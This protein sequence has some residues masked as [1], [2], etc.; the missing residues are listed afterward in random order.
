MYSDAELAAMHDVKEVF[1]PANRL[2]PGKVL[3]AQISP[4]DRIPAKMPATSP[5]QPASPEEAAAGLRACTKAERSVAIGHVQVDR[6][7]VLRLSTTALRDIRLFAPDDLFITVDAGLSLNAVQTFLAEHGLQTPVASPWPAATVGGL[8]A[9]NCNGPL[10]LRY[11]S[12]RDVMLCA[13][14]VLADGR[15][16]RAG[17][18]LVKNVAGYDLPKVFVGSWGTLGLLTD[19]TLK[20]T[21]RPRLRRTL[22]VPVADLTAGLKLADVI[23]PHALVASG[24]VLAPAAMVAGLAEEGYALL[25]TAEGVA[26]DV[27]EELAAVHQALYGAGAPLI[28]ETSLDATGAWQAFL[29]RASQASA[30]AVR[31]GVP[32]TAMPAVFAEAPAAIEQS[33]LLIDCGCGL[34][35][36]VQ[37]KSSETAPAAWLTELRQAA[38]R[39]GGYAIVQADDA[40]DTG[41]L[42]NRWGER[43]TSLPLMQRLKQR[44]DPAGILNPGVFL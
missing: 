17:R 3:P 43:S 5:W 20:L 25:Y 27:D 42:P 9:Q 15:I 16:I 26:E 29:R 37:A 41:H 13:T 1:D 40:L 11:G 21:P 31:V 14:V 39:H 6:E 7:D 36:L 33:H 24:I 10:R 35:Y 30:S 23:R 4:P 28:V 32:S 18:P 8:L 19:V 2:N 38:T 44:W 34:A 22:A 12:L